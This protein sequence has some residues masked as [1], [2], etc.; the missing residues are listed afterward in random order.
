[1]TGKELFEMAMSLLGYTTNGNIQ[2]RALAIVNK[3]YYE[4]YIIFRKEKETFV[5]LKT[6]G[7]RIDLPPE[8]LSIVMP[9]GIAAGIAVGEGDGDM[10][11]YYA[12]EYDR[13]RKRYTRIETII[14]VMGGACIY[15]NSE[16]C[17]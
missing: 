8:V 14:D 11:Q 9:M 13:A 10:Q 12:Y 16:D 6:L 2:R 1:M 3:I 17:E 5:P 7:D 15:G 4:M